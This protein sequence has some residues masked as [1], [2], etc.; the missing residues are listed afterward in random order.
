M[1]AV[2]A[3]KVNLARFATHAEVVMAGQVAVEQVQQHD[4]VRLSAGEGNSAIA[5]EMPVSG[6]DELIGTTTGIFWP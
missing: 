2:N 5:R 6:R 4:F 3:A 1:S